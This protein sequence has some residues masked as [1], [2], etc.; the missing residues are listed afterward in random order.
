MKL[1]EILIEHYRCFESLTIPLQPD[2]TVFVGV[3]GA[4]KTAVLDAI[5]L[6]LSE[7][8]AALGGHESAHQIRTSRLSDIFVPEKSGSPKSQN[9]GTFSLHTKFASHLNAPPL[10]DCSITFSDNHWSSSPTNLK[11]VLPASIKNFDCY[12][13]ITYYRAKRRFNE[14]PN[15]GDLFNTTF[16]RTSALEN[17]LDAGTNY[18]AMCQWFYLRENEELRKKIRPGLGSDFEFSDLKAIRH[19]L[20]LTI[21]GVK[22]VFFDGV[23]PIL[24]LSLTNL[25][26]EP[27]CRSLDQ[28]SDGYRSLLAVILD[29]ARRLAVANPHLGNPLQAP[30]ILLIDE[31]ELHLHP[32]WQQRIIPNL[33]QVF[34]NTQLIVATHSP[35]VLTTVHREQIRLIG[36]DHRLVEIPDD[37]GTYGAENARVLAEVF[38]THGRPQHI[39][40]VQELRTYLALIEARQHGSDAALRLRNSLEAALGRSDP[41][42]LY[43]DLR[44]K[45]LRALIQP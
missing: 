42:L 12:P 3:N 44:I 29:F 9:D 21:E 35:A 8:V 33:R 13:V 28:L 10:T 25:G 30:G 22:Q 14:M 4:G 7:I 40:T 6:A 23:P 17:A 32:Q 41:D 45:Q 19:A 2:V 31:I 27:E 5:A 38:G 36:S 43:A 26:G 1:V 11:Q 39:E 20:A 16:D 15:M 34:P 37:V 24:K 18:Q